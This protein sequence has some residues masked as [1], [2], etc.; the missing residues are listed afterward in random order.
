MYIVDIHY[1]LFVINFAILANNSTCRINNVGNCKFAKNQYLQNNALNMPK[2]APANNSVMYMGME[3]HS[4]A[5]CLYITQQKGYVIQNCNLCFCVY[6]CV[7][8]VC[9]CLCLCL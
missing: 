7:S 1:C 4:E 5:N 2:F 3:L 6:K 9:L 8:V